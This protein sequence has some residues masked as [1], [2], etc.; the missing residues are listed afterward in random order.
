MVVNFLIKQKAAEEDAFAQHELGLR[1]LIGKNLA[2]D[3][4]RAVFWIKKAV[5]KNLPP[6]HFNYAIMLYN[7]VGLAW[8]PFEAYKH[9][10]VAAEFGLAEAQFAL[11]IFYLD[12]LV[13]N[14]NYKTAHKWLKLSANAG[15][16]RAKEVID[17][18]VKVSGI[19][20]DDS[21]STEIKF[22][23]PSSGS[24]LSDNFEFEY[25]SENE[26]KLENV[27]Y[28]SSLFKNKDTFIKEIGVIDSIKT[29]LKT[30]NDY[31]ALLNSTADLGSP[32][33]LLILGKLFENGISVKKDL[34]KA[35]EYFLRA[36][37]LGSQKASQ[38][39]LKYA[40]NQDFYNLITK[41]A[42]TNNVSAKY[43]YAGLTAMG[44]LI[45]TV[46]DK[47]AFDLLKN[48][49]N[50]NHIPSLIEIGLC[51]SNGTLVNKDNNKALEYWQKA[52]NL[53]SNE[54]NTRITIFKLLSQ[55]ENNLELTDKL[56]KDAEKGS[57]LAQ[58]A[59]GFCYEKGVQVKLNKATAVQYYRNAAQRGN[60]SAYD[61]L[62]NMYDQ[63]RPQDSTF[64]IIKN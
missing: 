15:N 6:A 12:N 54:A 20:F 19:N 16:T 14:R 8:N 63:L 50:L 26:E 38:Y 41:T 18:I 59:L 31:L 11:A 55:N 29:D 22:S 13:V 5:D 25:L 35:S 17:E 21:L 40:Y 42:K 61:A 2:P 24:L 28:L 34:I 60:K 1:Y 37:R 4:T 10:K 27:D 47:Q 33:A 45:N 52:A 57:V 43:V 23:A 64:E 56:L 7:S 9:F 3:T 32:E 48:A 36:F 39:L 44:I 46:D 49:G 58:S 62:I 51:Y 53:G 30:D